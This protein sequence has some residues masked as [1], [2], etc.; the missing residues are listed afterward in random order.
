MCFDVVISSFFFNYFG[1]KYIVYGFINKKYKKK[2][3][4]NY[5][6]NRVL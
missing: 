3:L 5:A 4:N 6:N 1:C 2:I